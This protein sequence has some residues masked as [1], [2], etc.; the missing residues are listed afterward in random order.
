MKSQSIDDIVT[1][2]EMEENLLELYS[3]LHATGCFKCSTSDL[4][5]VEYMDVDECIDLCSPI[6]SQ[7][8]PIYTLTNS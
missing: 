3:S 2:L 8:I 4:A 6:N 1:F 7:E 5:S